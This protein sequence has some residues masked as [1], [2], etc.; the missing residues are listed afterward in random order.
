MR[1]AGLDDLIEEWIVLEA[2]GELSPPGSLRRGLYGFQLGF[3]LAQ[4]SFQN[5]YALFQFGC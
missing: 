5:I 1:L 4:L 3:Y 2:T